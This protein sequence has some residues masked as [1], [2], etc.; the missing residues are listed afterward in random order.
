ME[1]LLAGHL[2]RLISACFCQTALP[3]PFVE[4]A[5]CRRLWNLDPCGDVSAGREG[6]QHKLF[7]LIS[8]N[9]V[10]CFCGVAGGPAQEDHGLSS[11]R[12]LFSTTRPPMR[13]L[14]DFGDDMDAADSRYGCPV[15][16]KCLG[17]FMLKVRLC[18]A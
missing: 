11:V 7:D 12:G 6:P 9:A 4:T 2:H 13:D 5:I 1:N 10:H 3:L 15:H 17:Q 16:L 14:S 8:L 18:E